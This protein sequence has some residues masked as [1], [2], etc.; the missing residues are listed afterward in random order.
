MFWKFEKYE[1]KLNV[2]ELWVYVRWALYLF[3]C[4]YGIRLLWQ[5]YVWVVIWDFF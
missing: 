4:E 3:G 5:I 1:V 2:L